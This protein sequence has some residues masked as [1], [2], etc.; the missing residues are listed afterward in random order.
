MEW[1]LQAYQE[2]KGEIASRL[3]EFAAVEGDEQIFYE[4]CFCLL[5]P[6]SNG[7]RCDEAVQELMKRDFYT[8]AVRT[9]Q[10]LRRT[11][12]FHK[13]KARYLLLMKEQYPHILAMVR[14]GK[15]AEEMRAWLAEHVKGLGMKEASHFLRNIGYGEG[16]AIID[17]HVLRN[18]REQGI[19]QDIPKAMSEKEYLELEGK[20]REFSRG[21]GIPLAELDLLFWSKE[22][23]RV[24]K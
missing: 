14:S 20:L 6:Q 13:H 22:T 11:T 9:A 12:R 23:G 15:N 21:I 24:F 7:R 3:D 1:V 18:M 5:T 19:I 4:L 17:R 16:I 10:I 8:T 2:R